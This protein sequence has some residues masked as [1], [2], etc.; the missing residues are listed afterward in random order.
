M[1]ALPAP[2]PEAERLTI[3]RPFNR[4]HVKPKRKPRHALAND[5]VTEDSA[6]QEFAGRYDGRLRFCHGTGAWFEWTGTHWKQNLTGVAFQWARQLARDLSENQADRIRYLTSKT[7][8]AAGVERFAK[9]AP[10]FAVTLEEWDTD[11]FLL[12][13]PGGTVDLR[14][15]LLRPARAA[16]GITKLTSVAPTETAMCPLWLQFLHE[17]TGGDASLVR[18]LRQWAGYSLTGDTGEHALIF[19]CG[20]GGNGKSVFLNV[21]TGILNDYAATAA[22]DTF[23]AS[24][25]DKH[26]TDLAMLRG[27]RLVTASE[28]EEGKAWAEARIKQITGGDP[29]TARFMR[30]DNFTFRP[31]FKLTIVGNHKPV[32]KAVDDAV[33]RRFN[34]IPFVH[35]PPTPDQ[36][37]EERLKAEWSGILRWMMDGCLDWRENGLLRP[38]SVTDATESYLSDQDLFGQWIEECCDCDRGNSYKWETT[39][40]LFNSWKEFAQRAGEPAGTTKTFPEALQRHGF[41]P[42][43]KKMGRGFDGI[44]LT[45]ASHPGQGDG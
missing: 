11:P 16:E 12:G 28:T 10:E 42:H 17:A 36:H 37:L 41:K 6:A 24:R 4:E 18:F 22:M 15:G 2:S 29:I 19:V 20:P 45:P 33:R 9:S 23:T 8:F 7:S 13:T 34:I 35:K 25:N 1:E 26:T 38:Q 31:T 30:Q 43:R 39:T 27:A 5:L 44:R 40:V 32:L 14:R 3:A 21:L